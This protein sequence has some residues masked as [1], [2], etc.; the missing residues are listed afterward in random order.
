MRESQ[1]GGAEHHQTDSD[2]EGQSDYGSALVE[3][4]LIFVGKLGLV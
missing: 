1:P 4:V 2:Q 3:E